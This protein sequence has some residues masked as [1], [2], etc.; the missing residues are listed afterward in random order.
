[1]A[2]LIS[3][4]HNSWGGRKIGI[5]ILKTLEKWLSVIADPFTHAA[6]SFT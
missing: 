1:M 3:I 2:C 4:Y 5:M 6:P